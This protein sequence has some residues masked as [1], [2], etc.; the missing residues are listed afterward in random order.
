MTDSVATSSDMTVTLRR[1]SA[2]M[3][4]SLALQ[5]PDAATID[6]LQKLIPS[7]PAGLQP[8]AIRIAA[9]PLDEW[10]P[11]YFGILG[12]AGCPACESSYERG[13]M[14]SRGP[15]LA[16]VSAYYQA[17]AYAPDVR[18][19]PD[20]VSVEAG[21]L[22]YLTMKIAFAE[23]EGQTEAAAIGRDAYERFLA[24]HT[25]WM[26]EFGNSLTTTGSAQGA[27][28]ADFLNAVRTSA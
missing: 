4:A 23:H 20:H 1:A 9:Q 13:A 14:A 16:A 6:A 11:E 12:P 17:F 7:L 15:L 27:A 8:Q 2:W 10:E 28:I 3:F 19:V 18:E 21:F 26:E 25:G 24:E 5:P 22:S